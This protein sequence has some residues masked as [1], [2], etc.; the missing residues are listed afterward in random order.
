MSTTLIHT[1]AEVTPQC[2]LAAEEI[3]SDWF[4]NDEPI[5]WHAFYDRL[6]SVGW[7]ITDTSSPA[8]TKIQRH[9]RKFKATS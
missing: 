3:F 8:S 6:E 5:D 1:A 4:D 7:C 2:L 9:I